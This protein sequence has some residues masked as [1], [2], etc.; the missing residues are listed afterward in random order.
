MEA[1]GHELTENVDTV[2]STRNDN[3]RMNVDSRRENYAVDPYN[4]F[5]RHFRKHESLYVL[6]GCIGEKTLVL[7]MCCGQLTFA[8][9]SLLTLCIYRESVSSSLEAWLLTVTTFLSIFITLLHIQKS[10]AA[11]NESMSRTKKWLYYIGMGLLGFIDL[12]VSSATLIA[13]LMT[14]GVS[15]GYH[16]IVLDFNP[17]EIIFIWCNVPVGIVILMILAQKLASC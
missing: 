13:A 2:Q 9:A 14:V 5:H 3:I 6:L 12:F 1:E 10:M 15:S 16:F 11:S 8:H 4:S 7:L 17:I